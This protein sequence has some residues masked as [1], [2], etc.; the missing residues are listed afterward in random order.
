M[1]SFSWTITSLLR[2]YM[3]YPDIVFVR[4]E[5]NTSN[6]L[7]KHKKRRH[8][9]APPLK[10]KP[11]TFHKITNICILISY[12]FLV[13]PNAGAGE[14]QAQG[15]RRRRRYQAQAISGAGASRHTRFPRLYVTRTLSYKARSFFVFACIFFTINFFSPKKSAIFEP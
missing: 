6:P 10:K 2:R 5:D 12:E 8:F 4:E 1:G 9:S 11:I 14:T 15:K 3:W 7:L 13:C